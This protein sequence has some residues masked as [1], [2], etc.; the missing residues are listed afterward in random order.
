M[1]RRVVARFG[2]ARGP[3]RPRRRCAR[4]PPR[5]AQLPRL[6]ARP[7]RRVRRRLGADRGGQL[8]QRG[9]RPCAA[10]LYLVDARRL[11]WRGRPGTKAD[12]G[13]GQGGA[14]Q[15]RRAGPGPGRVCGRGAVQWIGPLPGRP[16]RR[17]AGLRLRR[18][19]FLRL[20]ADR[21][22]RGSRPE[23]GLR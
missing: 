13:R 2:H 1:G 19:G 21:A 17:A 4:H 22:D 23:R 10:P 8:D 18:P 11:A 3:A 14:H 7:C 6:R 9:D 5:R 16:R 20:V 12:R 15:G